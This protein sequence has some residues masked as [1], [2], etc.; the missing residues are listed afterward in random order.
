[1]RDYF[2]DVYILSERRRLRLRRGVARALAAG[3]DVAGAPP[4]ASAER[5]EQVPLENDAVA[6][7]LRKSRLEVHLTEYKALRDEI[8]KRLDTQ[9]QAFNYTV[10]VLGA[11]VTGLG[12]LVGRDGNSPFLPLLPHLSLLVPLIV[13]PLAF[14]FFDDELVMY[15]DI[16][17]ICKYVRYRVADQLG[18]DDGGADA[19]LAYGNSLFVVE[20]YG[21]D[22]LDPRSQSVHPVL[23]LG[24]WLLFVLPVALPP[25]NF[26][27]CLFRDWNAPGGVHLTM[28]W[29]LPLFADLVILCVLLLAVY[30][31][32]KEQASWRGEL[33]PEAS[34]PPLPQGR[35]RLGLLRFM[36]RRRPQHFMPRRR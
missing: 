25:L 17:H 4:A 10:V 33:E 28:P 7:A 12:I 23:S 3:A 30:A 34:A 19:R 22:W 16:F 11:I 29:A 18:W 32:L 14:I 6:E 2:L 9:R 36:P 20:A 24:R 15:R 21:F 26:I 31:A 27:Y 8:L 13:G 5:S 35:K 1:M